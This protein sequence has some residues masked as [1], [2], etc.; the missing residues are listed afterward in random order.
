MLEPVGFRIAV[1]VR[2]S[3]CD[4]LIE[5][6]AGDGLSLLDSLTR[7]GASV[8]GPNVRGLHLVEGCMGCMRWS[9]RSAP[10]KKE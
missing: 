4:R 10:G 6:L 3:V 2:C 7:K 8:V 1:E 9:S 5:V